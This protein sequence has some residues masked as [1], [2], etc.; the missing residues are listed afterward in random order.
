VNCERRPT[1]TLH[2]D[3]TINGNSNLTWTLRGN[4]LRMTWRRP[5]APPGGWVDLCYLSRDGKGY[6]GR[7]QH[8]T[9]IRG[10]RD[11]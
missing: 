3:G 2:P 6:V 1:I 8:G 10:V 11:E 5:G 4:L 9:E 7:N